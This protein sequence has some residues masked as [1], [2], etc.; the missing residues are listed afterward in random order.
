MSNLFEV[1]ELRK[2][3]G[4]NLVL[5]NVSIEF[6]AQSA[7]V[8]IG[9]SG[10]GKSTLMRCMNLLEELNDGQILLDSQDISAY[11]IDL[12]SVRGKIGS[13]FQAFNLFPHLSVVQNITLA[14]RLVHGKSKDEADLLARTLL[15]RF[16]LAEKADEYPNLLSGGQQQRV[17]IIRAVA[18]NPMLLL[19]DEVTSA[20]DPV[21][22]AEVL[23]LISELKNEGMTMVIAT[24]EMGFAKKIADNI[25]FLH[26]GRVHESGTPE[27]IFNAPQTQELKEFLGAL[28]Q[29]GRL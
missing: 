10:S 25:V 14:P 22:I 12:D 18:T 2:S 21:L 4:A 7:T 27:K 6:P 17:A 19:L 9:A 24:H 15:T 16:G 28:H 20:L 11:G 29:A 23:T 3:F 26:K 8:I 13:V 1:K 5:D